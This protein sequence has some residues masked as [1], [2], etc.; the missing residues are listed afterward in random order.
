MD[1]Q[2]EIRRVSAR[3][4]RIISANAG[5]RGEADDACQAAWLEF[6]TRPPILRDPGALPGWLATVARRYALRAVET[7]ARMTWV[8]DSRLESR[9]PVDPP[10]CSVLAAELG[11]ALWRAVD[12]FPDRHRRL[13]LLLAHCPDLRHRELAAELG[14]SPASVSRI[15]QRCLDVL[16]RRLE[17]EGFSC[18]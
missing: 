8:D 10:E 7:R 9:S 17:A 12:E 16:R 14:V 13:M 2:D 1:D 11:S 4:S 15:R 3:V 5:L 6:L 18:P